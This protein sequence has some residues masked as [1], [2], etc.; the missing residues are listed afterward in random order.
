MESVFKL[1]SSEETTVP[2][3]IICQK[4]GKKSK[5]LSHG[6]EKSVESLKKAATLRT[7]KFNPENKGAINRIENIQASSVSYHAT[8]YATFTSKEMINRLA[9][10]NSNFGGVVPVVHNELEVT[11]QSNSTT[12]KWTDCI[13][14]QEPQE[15]CK[16]HLRKVSKISMAEKI[17][18]LGETD[19]NLYARI[20]GGLTDLIATKTMYHTPCLNK[21]TRDGE[22]VNNSSVSVKSQA[23]L[24]LKE[25]CSELHI[26]AEKGEVCLPK[27]YLIF[28]SISLIYSSRFS[29]Y[30]TYG[31]DILH[32][33]KN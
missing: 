1:R 30:V 20:G 10:I 27:F 7:L 5:K 2:I 23:N 26:G 21:W 8:C 3:C 16:E 12:T 19:S 9:D 32:Y 11:A 29:N 28:L 4:P 33:Q 15:Q 24:A 25:I 13:F 6:I 18:K 22:K 31:P 17:K 14:C